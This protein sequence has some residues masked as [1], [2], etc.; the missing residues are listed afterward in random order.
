MYR[1]INGF[2][3]ASDA[4]ARDIVISHCKSDYWSATVTNKAAI[5]DVFVYDKDIIA[6]LAAAGSDAAPEKTLSDVNAHEQVIS[7]GK[8]EN[9]GAREGDLF[10]QEG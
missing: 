7:S 2:L 5:V 9:Y 8:K 4:D 6:G 10:R 3:S 1:G